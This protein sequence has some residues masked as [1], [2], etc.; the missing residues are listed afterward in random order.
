[1]MSCHNAN[2]F[3]RPKLGDP[4]IAGV[5]VCENRRWKAGS[6]WRGN[7]TARAPGSF[8]KWRFLQFPGW[9]RRAQQGIKCETAFCPEH[10]EGAVRRQSLGMLPIFHQAMGIVLL[11]VGLVVLPLPLPFGLI[12][13]TI[14]MALLAPYIPLVQRLVQ[15][16]RRKWP[17]VDAT[18]L[19]YRDRLPP[20]IRATI[21]KTDPRRTPAE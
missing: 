13:I 19:R 18:L 10:D 3:L 15:R 17:K 16:M 4:L 6:D 12:M 11:A 7:N 8:R 5:N 21:D 20:I 14:G 9:T 1:M 2:S